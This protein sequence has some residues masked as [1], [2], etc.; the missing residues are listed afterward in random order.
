MLE[1]KYP[2]SPDDGT[3]YQESRRLDQNV[4]WKREK[5]ERDKAR[6]GEPWIEPSVLEYLIKKLWPW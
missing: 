2:H 1:L 4:E 3:E 5:Y 6:C